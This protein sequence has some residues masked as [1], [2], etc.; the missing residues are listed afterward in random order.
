MT[1][2]K[3]EFLLNLGQFQ[4][5]DSI[6]QF[7][8]SKCFR[9]DIIVF[10]GK[11]KN[12]IRQDD[13]NKTERRQTRSMTKSNLIASDSSENLIKVNSPNVSIEKKKR[14]PKRQINPLITEKLPKRGYYIY[15]LITFISNL[16]TFQL[17]RF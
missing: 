9:M 4:E 3:I 1:L 5:K 16:Y 13:L 12:Q 2:W 8:V 7:L 15:E 10:T 11:R 6:G 17:H 14:G